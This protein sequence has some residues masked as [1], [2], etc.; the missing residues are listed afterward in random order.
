MDH[1]GGVH[2]LRGSPAKTAG[3]RNNNL[4]MSHNSQ[5]E[6]DSGYSLTSG[7][8]QHDHHDTEAGPDIADL[9]I[10]LRSDNQMFDEAEFRPATEVFSNPDLDYLNQH[11]GTGGSVSHLARESLYVKF[12]PLVGGRPSVMGRPSVAPYRRKEEERDLIAIDS[13]SPVR[14]KDREEAAGNDSTR[15]GDTSSEL[16]E[17]SGENTVLQAGGPDP[18]EEEKARNLSFQ[19]SLQKKQ[20]GQLLLEQ[21]MKEKEEEM[22]K[23]REELRVKRESEEQMKQV[24][25]EYEK[26]I[27]ELISDKEKEKGELEAEVSRLTAERDQ[28]GED[29]RNVEAAF[30][31]VHRKYERTKNVV[32]GFKSNEEK[33]KKYVAEYQAK[34]RKQDQKYELLKAHAEEKL[35]EANKE[36]ETTSR[37]QDAEVAKLT[38][39]LKKTEMKAASLERTVEQ[40]TRENQELTNIC[41]DLIAKVGT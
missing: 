34:L 6:S 18:K 26:T 32:E 17:R 23:L 19:R 22:R 25:K 5:N 30:A 37:S 35:E 41:D 40:R 4:M 7:S 28:A 24:L 1:L 31:D 3:E 20:Q 8:P 21:Q 38:A 29:L 27:S 9:D 15:Q 12:D 11:G 39:M 14:S 33:L 2:R 16:G 10:G 13:P 36:I